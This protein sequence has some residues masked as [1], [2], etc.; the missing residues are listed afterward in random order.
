[1]SKKVNHSKKKDGKKSHVCPNGEFG[2]KVKNWVKK[3]EIA[4]SWT[5]AQGDMILQVPGKDRA[6]EPQAATGKEKSK[7]GGGEKKK[8]GGDQP[9]TDHR[10][11]LIT[12]IRRR[13]WY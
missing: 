2:R 5:M 13:N 12:P 4:A 11:R 8:G 9:H 3:G 6:E 7:W 1:L 10:I